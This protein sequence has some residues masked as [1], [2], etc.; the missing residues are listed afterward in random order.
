MII[1]AED[2]RYAKVI[3]E[4]FYGSSIAD[5]MVINAKILDLI[6][7]MLEKAHS[8]TELIELVPRPVAPVGARPSI[9]WTLKLIRKTGKKLV[10]SPGAK[11]SLTFKRAIAYSFRG[12]L[13]RAQ[14]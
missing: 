14:L 10:T 1:S 3:L 8:C 9:K 2:K 7:Q 11:I 12:R 5:R 13:E 4:A 6:G